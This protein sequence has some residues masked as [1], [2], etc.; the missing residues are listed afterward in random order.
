M[1]RALYAPATGYYAAGKARIGREGDFLTNVSV[2]PLFGRM[3]ARQFAEMWERLGRPAQFTIVEQGAASGDFAADALEGLREFAPECFDCASYVIVEPL[4]IWCALQKQRLASFEKLRWAASLD[5]IEPF[6]GVHFSNEL[7]DSFPVHRVRWDG[8]K[9]LEQ[10][11]EYIGGAFSFV[12]GPPAAPSIRRWLAT[13]PAPPP[14]NYQTEVNLA[15]A[16]WIGVLAGKLRRGWILTID[17]GYTR[18]EYYCR[19]RING[20]LTGYVRHRQV[21]NPLQSPGETD[22]TAHVEFTSLMEAGSANGLAVCGFTDQHRFMAALSRLHFQENESMTP[23]AHREVRAFQML[24]HPSLMGGSFRALC[25]AK[26]V[27]DPSP[28]TGFAPP[29]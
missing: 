28:L 13:I 11:V 23:E 27:N 25:F 21:S 24:M 1:D 22:I 12:D 26:G 29:C 17:Y 5:A 7:V 3:L 15:S 20:T 16:D 2:G 19:E 8:L 10:Y 14:D 18:D 4:E 9:W 6:T